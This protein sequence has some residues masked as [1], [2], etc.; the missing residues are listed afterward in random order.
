M[1]WIY[2]RGFVNGGSSPLVY[3]GHHFA[4]NGIVF[5]SFNYRVGRFGFFGFP[6]LTAE[7]PEELHGNYGYMDQIAALKWVQRNIAAPRR[8][9][10]P[11]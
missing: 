6:G 3:S 1:V 2:G 10:V 5:V 11:R 4:E 8:R 7:H 9:P